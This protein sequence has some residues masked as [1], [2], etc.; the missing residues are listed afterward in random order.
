MS[1]TELDVDAVTGE[2]IADVLLKEVMANFDLEQFATL[3]QVGVF[4]LALLSAAC[5][6]SI[7]FLV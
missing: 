3:L 4:V 6:R 7:V 2:L 1:L 5:G